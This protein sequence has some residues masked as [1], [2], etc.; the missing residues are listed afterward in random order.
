MTEKCGHY[1]EVCLEF[2][3]REEGPNKWSNACGSCR[4]I[5]GAAGPEVGMLVSILIDRIKAVEDRGME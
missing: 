3:H 2:F 5:L 1:C 4:E